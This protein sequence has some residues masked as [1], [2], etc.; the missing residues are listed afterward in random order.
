M[1]LVGDSGGI[2]GGEFRG[3]GLGV[4][5]LIRIYYMHVGNAQ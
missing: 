4:V 5:D 3:E 1:R 2:D